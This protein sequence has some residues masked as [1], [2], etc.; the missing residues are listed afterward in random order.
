MLIFFDPSKKPNIF[1]SLF[2]PNVCISVNVQVK[3][4]AFGNANAGNGWTPILC[5]FVCVTTNIMSQFKA[6]IYVFANTNVKCEQAIS[7]IPLCGSVSL[8]HLK[9]ERFIFLSLCRK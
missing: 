8:V 4:C 7:H 6:D 5:V 2:P 3:Y 9:S 1:K